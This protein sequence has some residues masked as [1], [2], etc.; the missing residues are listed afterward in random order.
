[1]K[2]AVIS[3]DIEDW[4]HLEYFKYNLNDKSQS[5]LDEGTNEFINIISKENIKATFFV[6]GELISSK[7]E[8]LAEIINQ[9]HEISGHSFNHIRPLIQ[10][11]KEFKLDSIKLLVELKEKLNITSP[12]Y[13]APCFSLDN[14]RLQILKELNYA[15]DSSK[16]SAGFHPLY[17]SINID[18]YTKISDNVYSNGSFTEFELPTQSFLGKNVPISGGGYLRI[19]PW[20]LFKYL[21]K[22]YLRENDT[23]FFFIH[24]FELTNKNVSLPKDSSISARLRFRIGRSKGASRFS[25]LIK[26]LKNEGFEFVTFADFNK[27]VNNLE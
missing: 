25:R 8:L 24:P 7:Q 1:M 23:Y 20:F 11:V 26:I 14:E 3:I 17:G 21:L 16:I 19:L 10:S 27:E 5:V 2:K 4:Y 13:R 6:V 9:G 18:D 22:K 12:G 15:Y